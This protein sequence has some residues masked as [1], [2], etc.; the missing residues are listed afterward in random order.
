M[1]QV[2]MMIEMMVVMMMMTMMVSVHVHVMLMIS[3]MI[4]MMLMMMHLVN[5]WLTGSSA[6]PADTVNAYGE[7]KTHVI[8]KCEYSDTWAL[9]KCDW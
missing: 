6:Q 9:D 1:K 5:R 8:V 2:F 7:K 3:V 4:V